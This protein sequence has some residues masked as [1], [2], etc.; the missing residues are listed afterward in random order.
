MIQEDLFAKLSAD[1]FDHLILLAKEL[2]ESHGILTP[3]DDAEHFFHSAVAAGL[4][5]GPCEGDMETDASKAV[6]LQQD[7]VISSILISRMG[8][9]ASLALSYPINTVGRSCFLVRS[10]IT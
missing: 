4:E 5:G 1:S 7:R 6:L 9:W 3:Y 10:L 2:V 8:K